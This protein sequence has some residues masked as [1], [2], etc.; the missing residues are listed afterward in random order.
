MKI[1]LSLSPSFKSHFSQKNVTNET[2]QV[3]SFSSSHES[4]WLDNQESE[5][6]WQ[7]ECKPC[8]FNQM[9]LT[10]QYIRSPLHILLAALKALIENCFL[11]GQFVD[12]LLHSQHLRDCCSVLMLSFRK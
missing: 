8:V 4:D 11:Y 9:L 7:K 5:S 3:Q 2:E 6:T 12:T 1:E 10:N